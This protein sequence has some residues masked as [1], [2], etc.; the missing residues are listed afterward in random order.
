M[1]DEIMRNEYIRLKKDMDAAYKVFKRNPIL[2]NA[3]GYTT[4]MQAFTSFCVDAMATLADVKE[5]ENPREEIL[6]NI[7]AYKTCSHC[8][9]ILLINI[10]DKHYL[11][12]SE[13]LEDFPGW[14]HS[15]LTEHCKNTECSGCTVA[16]HPAACSFKEVKNIYSQNIK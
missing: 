1:L 14:C 3:S 13:F 2:S 16:A 8:D 9:K 15:C 11:E 5:L 10:D 4:A 6:N 12:S 7:D